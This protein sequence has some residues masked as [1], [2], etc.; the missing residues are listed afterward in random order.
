MS[1][2]GDK[3]EAIAAAVNAA[4]IDG[5]TIYAH[6]H[7]VPAPRAGDGWVLYRGGARGDGYSYLS[8]YA[9]VI[10]LPGDELIADQWIE[11]KFDLLDDAL[12]PELFVESFLP[13]EFPLTGNSVALALMITGRTE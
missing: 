4:E 8:T 5:V 13:A 6:R 11:D 3:R 10:M 2:I 7:E 1:N 9:V 12:R